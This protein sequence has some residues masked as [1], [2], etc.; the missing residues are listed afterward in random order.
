MNKK[1]LVDK[2]AKKAGAKKKDVKKIIDT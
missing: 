1:E 2:V